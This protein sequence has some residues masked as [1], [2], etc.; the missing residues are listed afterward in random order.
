MTERNMVA[1]PVIGT[2]R[3]PIGNAVGHARGKRT[4]VTIVARPPHIKKS[5]NAAHI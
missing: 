3:T 5:G 1:H 2:V 4:Q